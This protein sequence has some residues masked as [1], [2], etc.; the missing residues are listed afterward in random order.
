MELFRMNDIIEIFHLDKIGGKINKSEIFE[1]E[2]SKTETVLRKIDKNPK[3]S[4]EKKVI[5]IE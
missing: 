5:K 4:L 2:I 1:I 3:I